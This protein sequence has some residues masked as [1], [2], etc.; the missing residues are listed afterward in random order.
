MHST[1]SGAA[2]LM[3]RRSFSSALALFRRDG[4]QILVDRFGLR[5]HI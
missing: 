1:A 4:I 5:F 2:D 3:A